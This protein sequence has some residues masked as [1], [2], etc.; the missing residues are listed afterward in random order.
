MDFLVPP[1]LEAAFEVMRATPQVRV[2]NRTQEQIMDFPV[3]QIME[4]AVEVMHVTPEECVQNR[5]PGA[6]HGNNN[7]T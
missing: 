7:K 6:A 1:I 5:T 4:A 2:Q 3:P